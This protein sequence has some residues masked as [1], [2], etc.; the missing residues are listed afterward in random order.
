MLCQHDAEKFVALRGLETLIQLLK[1]IAEENFVLVQ[2]L[3]I[4]SI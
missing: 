1:G 4:D 3:P 2:G